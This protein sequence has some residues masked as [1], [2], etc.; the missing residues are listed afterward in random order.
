MNMVSHIRH[1]RQCFVNPQRGYTLIELVVVLAV[2]S[3]LA[4]STA[5]YFRESA[6]N[7]RLVNAAYRVLADVRY[8]QQMAVSHNR[9]V[10][11][12]VAGNGYSARWDGGGYLQSPLTGSDLSVELDVEITSGANFYF[13]W[14]GKPSITSETVIVGLNSKKSIKMVPNTG[15]VYIED[16]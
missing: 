13:D 14:N 8:A 6:E 16:I 2:A 5:I 15:Y 9:R 7:S 3:I 11:F 12:S 10:D 1:L 4:G